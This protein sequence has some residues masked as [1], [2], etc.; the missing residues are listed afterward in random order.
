MDGDLAGVLG[1]GAKLVRPFE[2]TPAMGARTSVFL[3]TSPSVEGR[4][5]LYW[6]RR[7]P[8]HMSAHA[9]NEEAPARLWQISEE[10]LAGAGFALG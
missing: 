8:G 9:R 5:G 7:K 2:I 10:L 6:A 4:T 1:L 3:A